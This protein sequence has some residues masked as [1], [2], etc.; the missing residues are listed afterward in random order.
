MEK[1]VESIVK[2]D[3]FQIVMQAD[4]AFDEFNRVDVKKR[5]HFICDRMI[6]YN[7]KVPSDKLESKYIIK[8]L[9]SLLVPYDSTSEFLEPFDTRT[10]PL[11][12]KALYDHRFKDQ[13]PI[14]GF[15]RAWNSV[16]IF[17]YI[18][19]DRMLKS[20][21]T[22][23]F[24][25][26]LSMFGEEPFIEH[27]NATVTL[28]DSCYDASV[29]LRVKLY[30]RTIWE[31]MTGKL[32]SDIAM[33]VFWFLFQNPQKHTLKLKN[34]KAKWLSCA[35]TKSTS[36]KYCSWTDETLSR[37]EYL[38]LPEVN[39]DVTT[40]LRL[41]DDLMKAKKDL[42]ES[43]LE[44]LA[45]RFQK[46]TSEPVSQTSVGDF[47]TFWFIEAL[48]G[49]L[50]SSYS[51]IALDSMVKAK[52]RNRFREGNLMRR[53]YFDEWYQFFTYYLNHIPDTEEEFLLEAYSNLTTR[54]NGLN[55]KIVVNGVLVDNPN[56]HTFR[57]TSS[58]GRPIAW[59]VTD[60]A[61]T[62]RIDPYALFDFDQMVRTLT[63]DDP[64]RLFT[65]YVPARNARMVYG[66]PI[67]RFLSESFTTYLVDW[68]AMQGYQSSPL[69]DATPI[70]TV[71]ID[72]G[73]YLTE[74]GP[75][76]YLTG[77]PEAMSFI[78]LS[79]FDQFDQT[80]DFSNWRS[81]A[82]DAAKAVLKQHATS[83]AGKSYSLLGNRNPIEYLLGNWETLKEAVFRVYISAKKFVD[84]P[85][86]W[87]FS[88]EFS[89]LVTNTLVN[90]AFVQAFIAQLSI[91]TFMYK[92]KQYCLGD[93]FKVDQFKLQGDDQISIIKQI[94]DG[95]IMHD[96]SF[97]SAAQD[98]LLRLVEAVA[99]S[100]NLIISIKKTELRSAYFEFLKKAGMWG[101]AVPR[102]MQISLEESEN[103]NRTMDPIERFRARIGQY[104]EYEFRGGNTVY[105]LVRRYI[106]WNLI[107]RVNFEDSYGELP[108]ALLW[109]PT[110][111]G[112]VGMHPRTVVDPNVDIMLALWDWNP[113]TRRQINYCVLALES[114][115]A[116]DNTHLVNEIKKFLDKGIDVQKALDA[117]VHSNRVRVAQDK[118]NLLRSQGMKPDK[119]AYHLRYDQEILEA[120]EDDKKMQVINMHW[121]R[122][123]SRAIIDSFFNSVTTNAKVHDYLSKLFIP[124]ITF[125]FGEVIDNDANLP[126][127]PLAGLDRHLSEW[128]RQ[129]GTS[130]E[131]KILNTGG[132]SRLNK[133]LNSAGFPRN[134]K[135]NN[136]ENIAAKLLQYNYL[137]V[138][139][140]AD[141]LMMRGADTAAA[142]RVANELAGKLD[143]LRYL[144]S[145]SAFSF[146]GEGF[147]DKSEY[148]IDQIVH[149]EGLDFDNPSNFSKIIK[150]IGYQFLRTA[151]LWKLDGDK[152]V[153]VERRH[154]II[155]TT[156]LTRAEYLI[157]M[158]TTKQT[159]EEEKQRIRDIVLGTMFVGRREDA[160]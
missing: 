76:L 17:Y 96:I 100:G 103:V 102:Y 119:A 139:Q 136:I 31:V 69:R 99:D 131:D 57:I 66:M 42:I 158:Y 159:T 83:L 10:I 114:A 95:A 74:M 46:M 147:T 156:E 21:I 116:K 132:F 11:K 107:R 37:F 78:L 49:Y 73:R 26:Y 138:E 2:G 129:I 81:V 67:Q 72:T 29:S 125:K 8:S 1:F 40:Y 25:Q 154:V 12:D 63:S 130:S 9:D 86:G 137:S 118:Y 160:W 13:S 106:E 6:E 134:L 45:D 68:I 59:K 32:E 48:S 120:I 27:G 77:H 109:T 15:T 94:F 88:G 35:F 20:P 104:R 89:T 143:L 142:I 65:R 51:K 41:K 98:A 36:G 16:M 92:D 60:K 157:Q 55:D 54:S 152:I 115:P 121:K 111:L 151:P 82:I 43:G 56:V 3:D 79:D 22:K 80:Q 58:D 47:S 145:V 71:A 144:S 39:R 18:F 64:G 5:W 87:E 101:Y 23:Y 113:L 38:D 24:C 85:T 146:V 34:M 84:V 108:F 110:S 141:F 4:L 70:S 150:S 140:I 61:L 127:C 62:F 93:I 153:T 75:Y 90:W 30:I 28:S 148:R 52:A 97:L 105:G 50:R 124:G 126:V 14:N 122:T 117:K 112:G 53:Y 44:K 91:T 7:L 123:R 133:M 128:L 33:E 149:F 155:E 135:A 19:R